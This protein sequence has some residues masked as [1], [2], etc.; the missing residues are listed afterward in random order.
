MPV[1]IEEITEVVHDSSRRVSAQIWNEIVNGGEVDECNG[2]PLSNYEGAR[3][4]AHRSEIVHVT[5]PQIPGQIAR[6]VKVN[7]QEM[8]P[9]R[10]VEQTVK[11]IEEIDEVVRLIPGAHSAAHRGESSYPYFKS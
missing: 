7:P 10:I 11:V 2:G 4:T 6:G 9:E 8:L 3:S 1:V 5:V